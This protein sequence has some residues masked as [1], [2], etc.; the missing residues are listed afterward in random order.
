MRNSLPLHTKDMRSFPLKISVSWTLAAKSVC[1]L[2]LFYS[3]HCGLLSYNQLVSDYVS[4]QDR[5]STCNTLLIRSQESELRSYRYRKEHNQILLDQNN[6]QHPFKAFNIQS[7][8][9]KMRKNGWA[10]PAVFI[11]SNP[12]DFG[13]HGQ[14]ASQ[15]GQDMTIFHLFKGKRGGYFVDLASNDA[16]EISN[17]FILEQDHDW[18]GICVEANPMYYEKLYLRNCQVVQAAV[19]HIDDEEVKFNFNDAIGGVIGNNFDNKEGDQAGVVKTLKTVSVEHI[20]QDLSV[21]KVIDYMSLDIE[22]AEEWVFTTFPWKRYT[23]LSI[24]VER[25]KDKLKLLLMS[26]GYKYICNHGGFGDQLWLHPTFPNLNE[27]VA[28]LNL[29]KAYHD[30]DHPLCKGNWAHSSF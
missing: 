7:W 30:K 11:G 12:P 14:W 23:F 18:N 20:F 8:Q 1:G 2:C 17:T 5:L 10:M 4:I 26:N 29:G 16:V 21:P 6:T 3:L 24:T 9:N 27:A 22:G 25:P 19:G 13:F 15:V 28:S